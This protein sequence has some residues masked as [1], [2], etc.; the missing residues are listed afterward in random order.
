MTNLKIDD[1]ARLIGKFRLGNKVYI[2]QGSVLRSIDDSITIGNSSWILENSTLIGT[3][4]YPLKVGS[5]TVF[6]HKC[7]AIGAE[8]GDLCEI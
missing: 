7:I 1:S 8:I 2:A 4:E 3:P 6:G 5:K